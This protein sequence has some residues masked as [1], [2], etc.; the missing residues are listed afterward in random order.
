MWERVPQNTMF[1]RYVKINCSSS[2]LTEHEYEELTK[3]RN[4]KKENKGTK[5]NKRKKGKTNLQH[6][7]VT[8]KS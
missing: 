7:A 3:I 4:F 6:N 8:T 1:I 2:I 5:V